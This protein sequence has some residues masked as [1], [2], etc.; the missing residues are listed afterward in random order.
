[1]SK[2]IIIAFDC[3]PHKGSEAM[4]AYKW[5]SMVANSFQVKLITDIRHKRSIEEQP[6][7]PDIEYCRYS[8]GVINTVLGKLRAY[9]VQ[10]RLF[11]RG[12]EKILKGLEL[13]EYK[14]IHCLTPAGC[15]TYNQLYRFHIPMA[16]GPLGGGLKLPEGFKSYR[17]VKAVLRDK[18]YER[19]KSK[20]KWRAYY[21]NCKHIFIG[22]GYLLKYL[23]ENLHC[24]TT[25]LFDTV[26]D[27]EIF[28]P[29]TKASSEITTI[30]YSGRMEAAKGCLL[31]VEAF[32]NLIR[33]GYANVELILLGEGSQS[34][35]VAGLIRKEKLEKFIHMPGRVSNRQVREYLHKADIFCLPSL[36]EPGGTAILEA[37]AC[38][39]PVITTNYGGPAISV[40]DDCGIKIDPINISQYIS[41]LGQALKYMID[42]PEQRKRMGHDA[43]QRVIKEYSC[44]KL[45]NRIKT[46]YE[47]LLGNP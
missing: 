30:L 15:Y 40:T 31:L 36:K 16:A 19:V 45:E 34:K 41:E 43:R 22:T 35:K 37:M 46:T 3:N 7:T 14:L 20:A 5:V 21:E 23:P 38:G 8:M 29:G 13:E 17:T 24:K 44:R 25:E 12:V 33:E 28:S 1:M 9:N 32:R 42:N 11:I 18:Y 47:A 6:P 27:T 39:I 10:Y 2:V 26:V 4:F